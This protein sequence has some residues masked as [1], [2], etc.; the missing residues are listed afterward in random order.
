MNSTSPQILDGTKLTVEQIVSVARGGARVELSEQAMA[1]VRAARDVVLELT[2]SEHQIYGL[3]TGLGANKD[4]RITPEDFAR[5]NRRIL[6]SHSVALPPFAGQ[7]TVRA[8]MLCRLNGLLNGVSGVDPAI[9]LLLRDML[10]TRIHP[11]IPVR[12]SVGMADLGNMAYVGLALIGEGTVEYYGQPM[13]AV[14]A[15]KQAGLSPIQLGPKDGLPLV[16]NNAF[17]MAQAA[18]LCADIRSL[19]YMADGVYALAFEAQEYNPMFL[20]PRS[21]R[22]R[23]LKGQADSLR[24]VRSYLK[25]S[26]LWSCQNE[27]L[28]G[29]L[30]YKSS[31]AIHGAVWDA[32]YYLESLLPDYLNSSDD[33]PMVLLEER[34]MISTDNF[35]VTGL[36]IA[37]DMMSVALAH[38]SH[39]I[40]NRI[41]RIDNDTFS[42]LPRF[43][44]PDDKVIAYSTIQKTVSALDGEIRHLANPASLDYLPTANESED[45]G[46]NT[47][48]V[49]RRTERILDLLRYLVGI[50]AMHGA[51]AADLG[52]GRPTGAGTQVI[53]DALRGAVPFL[54]EDNRDLGA[55]M[56]AAYALVAECKLLV[57]PEEADLC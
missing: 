4:V 19:L 50:E 13:P 20:D 24:H 34:E 21:L 6:F 5:F 9:L 18:L 38:L 56:Q 11:Q 35:I 3:N 40:A 23:P 41:L 44:R 15:L 52:Q 54:A 8:T 25:G 57:H 36:S 49:L 55:D 48:Y 47:P 29:A 30:S 1:E 14:Q 10:N 26:R 12:G 17:S 2:N 31:C 46:C 45:H 27:T 22:K 37:F 7:D 28:Y 39:L 16:S 53:Y 43:L 51:Q 33:C 32:L 42:G